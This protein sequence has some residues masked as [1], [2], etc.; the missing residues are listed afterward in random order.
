MNE[1]QIIRDSKNI[2]S[3]ND[4]FFPNKNITL[5][6]SDPKISNFNESLYMCKI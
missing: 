5:N 1:E 4:K 2:K 3:K 6:L